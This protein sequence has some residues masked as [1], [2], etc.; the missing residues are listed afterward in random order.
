M[1]WKLTA[2]E[3]KQ[4][5]A[6]RDALTDAAELL[7]AAVAEYNAVMTE[8]AEKVQAALDAYNQAVSEA[9]YFRDDIVAEREDDYGDKSEKWQESE[10]GEAVR[11]W[12]DEWEGAEL[13]DLEIE[14]PEELDEP[15]AAHADTLDNL[16]ESAE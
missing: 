11:S 5:D 9:R 13:D 1:A 8:H 2:A 3:A 10:K 14:F 12:I 16:P 6:L 15:D 7:Q 4:R